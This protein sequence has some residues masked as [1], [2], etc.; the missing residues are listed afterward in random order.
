MV[1][2]KRSYVQ[3]AFDEDWICVFPTEASAR[4]ALVDYA[5]HGSKQ[6]ILSSRAISFDTFKG[7]FLDHEED[8]LPANNLVRLLFVHQALDDNLP[9][10]R[11]LNPAYPESKSRFASFLASILPSL[12]LC[13][14]Y[15]VFGQLEGDLKRDLLILYQRYEQFLNEHGLFEP[16]Y[17]SLVV[18]QGWDTSKRYCVLFSD[19]IAQAKALY[20]ELGFPSWLELRP[21]PEH[22]E[23]WLEVFENHILEIRTTLRRIQTLFNQGVSASSIVIGCTQPDILLP[24]LLEEAALY[25][26]PLVSRDGKSAL[27]YPSG[28]FLSRI[29]E[30]YDDSFSLESL[31][32][33]LLEPGVPYKDPELG[34]SLIKQA[35]DKSI[36]HGSLEERDQFTELLGDPQLTRWYRGLKRSIIGVVNAKEVEELRRKLSAFQTD[37]FTEEQWRGSEDEEVY[38]FCLDTLDQIKIAMQQSGVQTYPNLFSFFLSFLESKLY[39]PQQAAQGI[40]VYAW[41]QVAGICAEYLFVIGLDQES[42]SCVEAPLS[43]LPLEVDETLRHE[44]DTTEALLKA[45]SAPCV[46]ATLSCHNRRYEGEMLPAS[47]FIQANRLI[48]HSLSPNYSDD[49]YRAEL[50]LYLSSMQPPAKALPCQRAAFQQARQTVLTSRLD[51]WTRYPIPIQL[52]NRLKREVDSKMVL[53]LSQTQTDLF[54]RCPYAWLARYLYGISREEYE[55]NRIDHPTIGVLLHRVYQRFFST[56]V[57]FSAEKVDEY[58]QLL[59]RLFDECLVEIYGTEGPTPSVRTWII[60]EY[61]ASV[62]KI[63][64]QEAKMFDASRSIGFELELK[65]CIDDLVLT[66]RIDR[67]VCL[68]PNTRH[69]YAVIDYKKGKVPMRKIEPK[70][71]SYQ[72]PLYRL[73][74]EEAYGEKAAHAAYYSVAEGKYFSIWT[75]NDSEEANLADQLLEERLRSLKEAVDAGQLMATPTKERC[76]SCE[77]RSLCRRRYATR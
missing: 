45:A 22:D 18:P 11:L 3:R 7:L 12:K 15:S 51:D 74:V 17:A 72:L 66:G 67:L 42:A 20:E 5:L 37:Y 25:D 24:Q 59:A 19:T 60:A 75:E 68:D 38:S 10:T 57:D 21:S 77:Y 52:V 48:Y 49:P 54:D 13:V 31:K 69:R 65:R 50:E 29:Q 44:V 61:R 28:R 47:Y 8:L 16:R 63:I 27:S 71:A 30:V 6:A 39:V 41:P 76:P 32:S 55:A 23:A 4:S 58:R 62:L 56:I 1:H 70:P 2:S 73:L 53:V 40:S 34:R 35:V 14:D 36:L 33:L 26:I 46:Q 43:F 9:L 64:E